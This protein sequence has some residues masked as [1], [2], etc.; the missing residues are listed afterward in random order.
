MMRSVSGCRPV[1][2]MSIQMRL[3]AIAGHGLFSHGMLNAFTWVFLAALAAATATRLWLARARSAT[4]ARIAAR[5]R[6]CSPRRS[7]SPRTRRPPTTPWPRR[8]SAWS[9]PCSTRVILLAL[10]FGGGLQWLADAVGARVL[11]LESLWHGTALI[12]SVFV[13]QGVARPAARPL[14]HLRGRGALR[15]QPHDA[16]GCTSSTSLKHLLVGAVLGMPLLLVVL[17][18]MQAAGRAVVAV[19]LGRCWSPTRCSCR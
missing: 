10:T 13:L 14:P 15:L 2:S 5:C 3:L 7:R 4:C 6:Q 19:R 16:A 8:G 9:T 18:L 1:I 12:L 17:W 11:P